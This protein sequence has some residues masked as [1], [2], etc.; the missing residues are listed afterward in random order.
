MCVRAGVYVRACVRTHVC[1]C[2]CVYACVFVRAPVCAQ[3]CVSAC[4]CVCVLGCLQSGSDALQQQLLSS[5]HHLGALHSRRSEEGRH[6]L[7]NPTAWEREHT[8]TSAHSHGDTLLWL[9]IHL[10]S[11]IMLRLI[12]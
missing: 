12:P 1:V 3:T 6:G 11:S 4:V 8:H 2:K 9:S 5:Q 10:V 7:R